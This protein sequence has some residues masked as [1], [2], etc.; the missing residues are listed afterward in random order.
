MFFFRQACRPRL[1]KPALFV[2][3]SAT[4]F[5]FLFFH[6]EDL[7]P[8][9]PSHFTSTTLIKSE[10]AS[11][12]TKLLTLAIPPEL[13]LQESGGFAPICSVFVKDSDIQVERPYTPLEGIDENNHIRLW[14]K[15]YERGEV[16]RWLHSKKVGDPIEIRGPVKT[17]SSSWQSGPWDEVILACTPSP[18]QICEPTNPW[19]TLARS[20]VAQEL[21]LST[22]FYIM[23][24]KRVPV[25][26]SL[27]LVLRC[28]TDPDQWRTFLLRV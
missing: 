12:N 28:F 1:L 21:H 17:W 15:K 9:S 22:S 6:P 24:S 5:Y 2:S 27:K 26:S 10:D 16:S 18:S 14:V 25:I 4:T 20:P 7:P 13:S 11:S 23:S 3:V 8:L 19:V